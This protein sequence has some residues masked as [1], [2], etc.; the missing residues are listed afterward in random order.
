[1][2]QIPPTNE[3]ASAQVD[4]ELK[5]AAENENQDEEEEDD[6]EDAEVSVRGALTTTMATDWSTQLCR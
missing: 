3:T 1:M 6:D 2:E 4:D 5:D